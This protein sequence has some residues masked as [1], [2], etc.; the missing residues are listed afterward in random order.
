MVMHLESPA[1]AI[2]AFIAQQDYPCVGA[3]TALQKDQIAVH[4][5][6]A[7]DDDT[8]NMDILHQLYKFIDAF[9]VSC[10]MYSSLVCTFEGPYHCSEREYEK[11]LWNKLQ[12]LHDIDNRLHHWDKNV[13]DDPEKDDFSFSVGGHGFFIIGLNPASTRKSRRFECPA[14]VFNLH[15]QFEQ[16]REEGKFIQF[17]DHIRHQDSQ[18]S[19]SPNPML[20]NHGADSEAKQYSGRKLEDD[21][22]CPFHKHKD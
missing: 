11:L 21:W 10:D 18:F 20:N 22:Q 9:N 14:I 7:I 3:K 8:H 5:F 12:Q 13:S 1:T 2:K 16:L 15:A 6:S 19:G 4:G 17:R